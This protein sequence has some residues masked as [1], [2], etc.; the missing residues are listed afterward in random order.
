V[1]DNLLTVTTTTRQTAGERREA[2][3]EAARHEF[4]RHGLHGASTDA[5]ARRAGISQ[6]YLFRLF[7]SKKELFLAVN[8]ACFAR[9][10]DT[11]RAAASG[12]SGAEA[13][14]AIGDSYVDLIEE[15]RT[16]LQ[17]QLQA[18]AA[19]V[20]DD[21][22]RVSAAQGYGRLVDYVETVSGADRQTITRFFAKGMLLN[23]LAAMQY[24]LKDEPRDS[25][26]ARLAEGFKEDAP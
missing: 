25:W 3:L 9:T 1:S 10:L 12:K 20:E 21:D 23:V 11:F 17:G 2:V 19:S 24:S 4:A 13:L 18:Y 22:I 8:D 6:P 15:D 7:G 5:I 14:R 26:A 16:M